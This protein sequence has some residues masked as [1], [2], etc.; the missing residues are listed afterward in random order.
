MPLFV[1]LM[2][3]F[4]SFSIMKQHASLVWAENEVTLKPATSGAKTKVNGLPLTGE[5]VLKH[6]DRILFG[7]SHQSIFMYNFI[8]PLEGFSFPV[9]MHTNFVLCQGVIISI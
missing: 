4:L 5:R 1:C 3:F 7:M 2:F 6:L 9:Y 8:V